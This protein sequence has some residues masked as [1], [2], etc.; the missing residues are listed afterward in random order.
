[1]KTLLLND[2]QIEQKLNRLAYQIFE[3]SHDEDEIIIA[4]IAKNGYVLAEKIISILSGISKIK[5]VLTE[6][7]VSKHESF[8]LTPKITLSHD[9]LDGKT[10]ILIDDVMNSGKTM[11]V[12][13]KP[14]LEAEIKKIR[15]LVLVD[16]NHKD[17][18]VSS[19]F[20]GLSLATTLKEHVSVEFENG[21]AS[22]WIQ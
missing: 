7:L 13:M 17:Y 9:Q 14:F 11:L 15:T 22:A 4:G 12:A 18:P 21:K 1:M 6:V 16:R 2:K 5:I 10:V 20:V 8:S 3:D 19:D